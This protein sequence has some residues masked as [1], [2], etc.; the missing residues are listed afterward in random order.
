[1]VVVKKRS[2]DSKFKILWFSVSNC[3]IIVAHVVVQSM[4]DERFED[5][6][7]DVADRRT[8]RKHK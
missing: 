2:V 6:Y 1:M 8:T 7:E 4:D 5:E 3:M